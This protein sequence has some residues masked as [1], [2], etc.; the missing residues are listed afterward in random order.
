VDRERRKE[1]IVNA[2]V[3]VGGLAAFAG[4][5]ALGFW[6]DLKFLEFK[7]WILGE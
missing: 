2:L 3:I 5:W 6:L 7:L 4:M 1:K